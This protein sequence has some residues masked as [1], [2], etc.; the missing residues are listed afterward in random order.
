MKKIKVIEYGIDDA[1]LLGV[2]CISMVEQPA[3]GVD[4]V[5]LSEQH[6]VKFKEDFRG[7]LYG[8][9]LIPDQLIYRRD[10]KTEEEYYV[11]YS[12]DTIRAIAYNYLKQNMTNNATVE[13]AKVVEGVS[14]V[15]TWI[16]EGEHDKSKNFGFDLPEGTWFGCMKVENEEVKKQIQNK[17]VLGFSIEGNFAVEKEMYLSAQEKFAEGQP[18]Y[19]ADGKLYEGPTHKN[20]DRLMT[21]A[22]HTEESEY[23]YHADELE[24]L[25][26]IVDIE[27]A[28]QE[29]IDARYDDYMN[30]V[31]MT[32]SELKAWSETECSQL[33]SLDRGPINR[34]LELLQTNKAEWG[35]KEYNDAGKTIA[36]INRMRENDAGESVI[37]E[38][39]NECGS[40]RTISLLNWAYDPNK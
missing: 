16:I 13:H 7:L 15:E 39:G 19:T 18:H 31:N 33:A 26:L 2:F 35:E 40:K 20:N 11:K 14:L 34:N 9:L 5:A 30:A 38:N 36:F 12:K 27:Q 1:G 22:E 8:A 37:D 32:Y 6:S 21:G 3:I 17:E 10:D 4:F 29:E 24:N 28:I 25:D 23:L